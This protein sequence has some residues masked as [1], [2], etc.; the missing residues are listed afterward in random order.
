M[1]KRTRKLKLVPTHAE[2]LVIERRRMRKSQG[3]R[4]RIYRVSVYEYRQWE[5]GKVPPPTCAGERVKGLEPHEIC[6]LLRTRAG[7]SAGDLA[8]TLGVSR[9]WL[10]QMERG[11]VPIDR[12][13]AGWRV[14]PLH[15]LA[16]HRARARKGA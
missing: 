16:E 10:T 2:R 14:L 13:V 15:R 7:V 3:E 12:L 1:K 9:W 8:K 5:G 11:E 6:F 4:A